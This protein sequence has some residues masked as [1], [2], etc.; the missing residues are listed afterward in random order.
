MHANQE[1]LVNLVERFGS[2]LQSIYYVGP[3]A[4]DLKKPYTYSF[5]IESIDSAQRPPLYWKP[6]GTDILRHLCPFI[7]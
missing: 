1:D 6:D 3:K 4:S 2:A 7:I 5:D